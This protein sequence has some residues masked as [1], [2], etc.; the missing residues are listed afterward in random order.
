[1]SGFSNLIQKHLIAKSKNRNTTLL[2]QVLEAKM[3]KT[4]DH[5]NTIDMLRDDEESKVSQIKDEP[6][7]LKYKRNMQDDDEDVGIEKAQ[8]SDQMLPYGVKDDSDDSD[9]VAQLIRKIKSRD[10]PRRKHEH[11]DD[12]IL[13]ENPRD[14][15]RKRNK[16]SRDKHHHR[17]HHGRYQDEED[18]YES[19]HVNQRASN[20]R[21]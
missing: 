4:R 1:M 20:S 18:E 3:D 12:D 14:E 6:K 2:N 9:G 5:D 21:K 8:A 19:D 15:H 11:Q 17:S 13:N 7:N 16:S 10:E